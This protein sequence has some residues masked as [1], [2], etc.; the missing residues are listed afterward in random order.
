VLA[1]LSGALVDALQKGMDLTSI[2]D[3]IVKDFEAS[4]CGSTLEEKQRNQVQ[5]IVKNGE[6]RFDGDPQ[7]NYLKNVPVYDQGNLGICYSVPAAQLADYYRF[8]N[9]DKNYSHL[10]SP[11]ATAI[12]GKY[13][14]LVD[15]FNLDHDYE[16][17]EGDI[18]SCQSLASIFKQGSCDLSKVEAKIMNYSWLD[19][20][21]NK[22]LRTD[23]LAMIQYPDLQNKLDSQRLGLFFDQMSELYDTYHNIEIPLRPQASCSGETDQSL[24]CTLNALDWGTGIDLTMFSPVLKKLVSRESK[25]E[26]F[27]GVIDQLCDE[28]RQ[29]ISYPP[30]LDCM[31]VARKDVSTDED[32]RVLKTIYERL[33]DKENPSPVIIGYCASV[34]T[35]GK[36]YRGLLDYKPQSLIAKA[37]V[38]VNKMAGFYVGGAKDD[39]G[40]HASLIT[41]VREKDG[42]CQLLVRNS[43]GTSCNSYSGDWDC[44]DGSVWVD[45]QDLLKNV[46]DVNYLEKSLK[47]II[48]GW[49]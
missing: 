26:F 16:L 42:Q 46:T 23:L 31:N 27:S 25:L 2:T 34:L 43:W 14:W 20:P 6:Y 1:Q 12:K 41:G 19:T 15:L 48:G 22:E 4:P 40:G 33:L 39:C 36:G 37:L 5:H 11:V 3:G 45:E 8:Q 18:E 17:D 29:K 7:P 38:G 44:E 49:L 24:A 30:T 32:N 47:N 21:K 28:N 10:T 35:E 9:G 13:S